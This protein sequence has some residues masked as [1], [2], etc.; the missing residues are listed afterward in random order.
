[1]RLSRTYLCLCASLSTQGSTGRHREIPRWVK[2]TP[3]QASADRAK[4]KQF[5]ARWQINIR[6]QLLACTATE[7]YDRG[8][9]YVRMTLLEGT[10]G[11]SKWWSPSR[12]PDGRR[13]KGQ[14]DRQTDRRTDRQTQRST[15]AHREAQGNTRNTLGSL[16]SLS[17]CHCLCF[18]LNLCQCL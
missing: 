13:D 8:N 10:D 4:R 11:H 3:K 18:C 15:R 6:T 7:T 12:H 5:E 16:W 17:A 14:T 9:W 1:M 2:P